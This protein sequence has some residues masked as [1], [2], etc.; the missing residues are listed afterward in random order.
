MKKL[1]GL[2]A[3][4]VDSAMDR[5]G[6]PEW[7]RPYVYKYVSKNKVELVK[8]AISFVGFGRKKGQIT[9]DYTI[10]PNG[11]KFRTKS[12]I[13]LVGVFFHGE[14]RL[15]DL[16]MH[17]AKVHGIGNPEYEDGYLTLANLDYK[18][19]R[20]MKNLMEGLKYKI[21]ED[22]HTLDALFNRMEQLETW[23]ERIVASGII[24]DYCYIKPFAGIFMRV[25]YPVVPEFMRNFGKAFTSKEAKERWDLVEAR[26]LIATGA[27]SKEK[28]AALSKELLELFSQ[29]IDNNM[30]IAKELGVLEEISLLKEI[31]YAYPVHVLEEL[32]IE[33]P[34]EAASRKKKR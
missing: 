34:K 10:L 25:F 32:G 17:W 8:T 5:Y 31:S 11:R 15:A 24:L 26:R 7:A 1:S 18:G 23:E 3:K 19:A 30:P 21:P 9:D 13:K 29:S 12:I 16:E 22:N 27:I 28:A 20:A 2:T 4:L 14:Q 33:L 6:V